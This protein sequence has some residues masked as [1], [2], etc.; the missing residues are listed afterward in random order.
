LAEPIKSEAQTEPVKV[1]APVVVEPP[2][3]VIEP[4]QRPVC[5]LN[6]D[7]SSQWPCPACEEVRGTTKGLVYYT[8]N[9]LDSKIMT[10]VQKQLK[11]CCNGFEI[12]SVSLQPIDF[13]KNVVLPLERS[14]LTMF[15]EILAGIEASTA[16][17]IFLVEHDVLYHPSHFT[18]T[19]LRKNIFYY[20]EN[21][22]FVDAN[23]GHALFYNAMS[24][25]MLVACRELLLEHYSRRVERVEAEG[26]TR[27]L[28][29]EPGNHPYPRGVDYY[30]RLPFFA[31]FPS[32]DIR[33][34]KNLTPSRWKKDEFRNQEQ[35]YAWTE[36][37]EIPYWGRTKDRFGEI[38]D[39]VQK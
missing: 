7:P 3:K 32:I 34:R 6:H 10:A 23:T 28:G 21:R 33:H 22:W 39:E 13:G 4:P 16:D 1:E 35:L 36:A 29:F 12:T 24:T 37:E 20:D 26:F 9:R 15:K 25:S 8:D 2:K 5:H 18:F 31:P 11:K 27:R 14:Y 38:L 17:I 30:R 19:P